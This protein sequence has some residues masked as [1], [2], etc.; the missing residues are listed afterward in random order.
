VPSSTSSSAL[1]DPSSGRLSPPKNISV[2][3]LT[4]TFPKIGDSGR[5][6]NRKQKIRAGERKDEQD[7]RKA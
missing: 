1:D 4:K 3:S 7:R 2:L 5:K 6:M